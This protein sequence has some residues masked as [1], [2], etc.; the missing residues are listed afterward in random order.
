MA[1]PPSSP[2]PAS[3]LPHTAVTPQPPPVSAEQ[4]WDDLGPLSV[5]SLDNSKVLSFSLLTTPLNQ[6][7]GEQE[8]GRRIYFPTDGNYTNPAPSPRRQ[9]SHLGIET[10]GALFTSVEDIMG[11]DRS[12]FVKEHHGN[13]LQVLWITAEV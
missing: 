9:E 11:A 2:R 4:T 5:N 13:L 3:Q 7:L 12:G 1:S 6:L 10:V 8:S